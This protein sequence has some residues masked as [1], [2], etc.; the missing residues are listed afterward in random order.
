MRALTGQR[1]MDLFIFTST[2]VTRTEAALQE[3]RGI[4]AARSTASIPRTRKR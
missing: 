2:D 1:Y 3:V 4:L